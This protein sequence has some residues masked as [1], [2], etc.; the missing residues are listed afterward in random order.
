MTCIPYAG[1]V[2]PHLCMESQQLK[3][4]SI[5]V[6]SH[7]SPSIPWDWGWSW[8]PE[9]RARWC[10]FPQRVH[11]T[12]RVSQTHLKHTSYVIKRQLWRK[13]SLMS[14]QS[15]GPGWANLPWRHPCKAMC[16]LQA[17]D[18]AKMLLAHT[19]VLLHMLQISYPRSFPGRCWERRHSQW[20]PCPQGLED[21]QRIHVGQT[22]VTIGRAARQSS[23]MHLAQHNRRWYAH[24]GWIHG[25]AVNVSD[26][27]IDLPQNVIGS[28]I[29]A[30]VDKWSCKGTA[31]ISI[32]IRSLERCWSQD[33]VT[34]T[35]YS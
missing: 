8:W 27:A 18:H 12:Q 4:H 6:D 31:L 5:Y 9:G 29:I 20:C 2:Y 24:I 26:I 34:V 13:P 32:V 17:E 28:G 14:Y 1:E 16:S 25:S 15:H 33:Y 22:L 11:C 10:C 21:E 3:L 30:I 19:H 7:T 23:K 35:G